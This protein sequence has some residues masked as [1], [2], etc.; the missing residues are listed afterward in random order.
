MA[1]ISTAEVE[2]VARLA[3]LELTENEKQKLTQDMGE[4]LD[5]IGEL[6][7]AETKNIEPI[8]Q[9]SGLSNIARA[10]EITNE[11]QRD[12]MLQ[13]A[14]ETKDGFIKVKKVFES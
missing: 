2:R 14:P 7:Q 11:N 1:E 5:Y 12:Q 10:D 8:S 4:I 3:R 13:N 6:N 9:I